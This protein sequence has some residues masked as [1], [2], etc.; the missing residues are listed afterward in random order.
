MVRSSISRLFGAI[1]LVSSALLTTPVLA[2]PKVTNYFTW[3]RGGCASAGGTVID[4]GIDDWW[5][6]CLEWLGYCSQCSG[7]N[8]L[9]TFDLD[10]EVFATANGSG[11]SSRHP[12]VLVLNKH[13]V[14]V[15]DHVWAHLSEQCKAAITSSKE[16]ISA[17]ASKLSACNGKG[18]HKH[19]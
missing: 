17:G 2:K 5:F 19:H 7:A 12:S 10:D 3:T 16:P 11:R 13:K 18:G 15:P 4:S 6:C 1:L 14:S 9:C 8:G